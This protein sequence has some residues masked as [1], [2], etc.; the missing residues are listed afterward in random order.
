MAQTRV[1][2]V[3]DEPNV[4]QAIQIGLE[5]MGYSVGTA[6]TGQEAIEVCDSEPVDVMLLDVRMTP[7]DGI[8]VLGRVKKSHPEI[9]VIM[10]T[11]HADVKAAVKAIKLGAFDYILKPSSA[12]ELS[13]NIRRAVAFRDLAVENKELKRQLRAK[14]K[15]DSI[16]GNSPAM[17]EVFSMME[18]V[19][20]TE[21]T[22]LIVGAT[23][24]GKELVARALHYNGPRSEKRL[25][26]LHCAAIP[27]HLFESELFGH[28]KGAFTG[29][30]SRKIGAFEAVD[31][32]T[33]FLDEVGETPLSIQAKLL[34]VLQ[35]REIVR[36]GSTT[37]IKVN[38][39]LIAAT[40][41]DLAAEVKKGNFREDLYYR[42]N[43]VEIRLPLLRE[44]KDDIPLL[45]QH[46]LEKYQTE[47]GPATISDDAM[48]ALMA[49]NWP[50][51]VR[52]LENAIERA[53]VLSKGGGLQS[54]HL[55]RMSA[56]SPAGDPGPAVDLDQPLSEARDRFEQQYVIG[57]LR[58][59]RGN[60]SAAAKR[61]GIAWQNFQRKLKKFNINAKDF[62]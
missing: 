30:D 46:L 42:L 21:S 16:I 18:C 3:D 52:E 14:H 57:L 47:A 15:F 61:A 62:S 33:F 58:E 50:G 44:R 60:I 37:P 28:E 49:H 17:Q 40:N 5:R 51:N 32:G 1:L 19:V 6:S 8:E 59:T 27:E 39:R 2:V 11:A 53:V 22:V 23:G 29:A 35:E 24:T 55:P 45:V 48:E 9:L 7:L 38:V 25:Y 10:I 43:V 34:R 4:A 20:D 12:D 13:E 54:S 41:R 36:V 56:P 31:G 26:C